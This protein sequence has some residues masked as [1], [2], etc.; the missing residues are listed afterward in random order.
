MPFTDYTAEDCAAVVG[1]NLTHHAE[2]VSPMP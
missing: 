1:V 2:V